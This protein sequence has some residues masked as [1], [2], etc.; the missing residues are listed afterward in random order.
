LSLLDKIFTREDRKASVTGGDV[1][2]IFLHAPTVAG[3]AVS[4][5]KALQ[6]PTALACC[7]VISQVAGGLPLKVFKRT[8]DGKQRYDDHPADII[9]SRRA[10]PWTGAAE[11]RTRLVLDALLYGRG[12]GLIVRSGRQVREVHRIDP[13]SVS[14]DVSGKTPI[15]KITD[16]EG[17]QT[18]YRYTDVID[19]RAPG[20]TVDRP[21][22]I[23]REAREVIALDIQM[24]KYFARVVSKDAKPSAV[25]TSEG[26]PV[27]PAVWKEM[28]AWFREQLRSPESDGT[29]F[30]PGQFKWTA[31]SM[32]SV[33]L[34]W[35]ANHT[36]VRQAI[37]RA[38][39]VPQ[40]AIGILDKASFRNT[41]HLFSQWLATGLRAWLEQIE[42]SF[43]VLLDD[44]GLFLEAL[45]DDLLRAD[46]AARFN[47]YRQACGTSWLTV[48][49]I[50]A[51]DNRPSLGAIGDE[52]V[53]Q[54]GQTA[55]DESQNPP[56]DEYKE[57]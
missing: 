35:T 11:L 12:L 3:I 15:Y 5:E 39:N 33:D 13:Q 43:S 48:N 40:T 25:V 55:A 44:E 4:G 57:D 32:S 49:E 41:E 7:S 29:L 27:A 10:N 22:C 21:F 23:V 37:A 38:F 54:A 46:T 8:E 19:L 1:L 45:T 14:V 6:S 30:V 51:L 52:L 31:Q 34:E 47:A 18:A 2:P 36:A 24:T 20:S 28:Q 17:R 56:D 53:R 16:R 50:R 9:L 26:A 42:N